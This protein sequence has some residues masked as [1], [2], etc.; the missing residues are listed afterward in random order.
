MPGWRNSKTMKTRFGGFFV[1]VTCKKQFNSFDHSQD[2]NS[3]GNT[4]T[5]PTQQ[6]LGQIR[7]GHAG[8]AS[9]RDLCAIFGR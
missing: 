5:S 2:G 4:T 1:E 9:P 7:R 8:L 6:E 3:K